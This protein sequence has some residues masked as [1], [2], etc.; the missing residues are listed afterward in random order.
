MNFLIC[1]VLGVVLATGSVTVA[2]HESTD[3]KTVPA[4]A[5]LYN[6]GTR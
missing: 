2:V 3:A 5:Q 1:G 6:Y 4:S